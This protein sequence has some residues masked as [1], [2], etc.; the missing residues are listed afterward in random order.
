MAAFEREWSR[1]PA[2]SRQLSSA[3]DTRAFDPRVFQNSSVRRHDLTICFIWP[4]IVLQNPANYPLTLALAYLQSEFFSCNFAFIAAGTVISV[5]RV[6]LIFIFFQR[7]F[8]EGITGSLKG[9]VKGFVRFLLFRNIMK[10]ADVSVSRQDE[11]G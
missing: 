3:V 10:S 6:T 2:R 9:K 4:L 11:K 8:V 1:S 7:Q 5:I